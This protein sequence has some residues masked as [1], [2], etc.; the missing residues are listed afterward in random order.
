MKTRDLQKL[1]V[2]FIKKWEAKR[3]TSPS[4]NDVFIHLT[5][6]V[7]ELAAQ[8]VSERERPEKYSKEEVE[9]ALGDIIMMTFRLAD[10]HGLDME[11]VLQKIVESEL[12]LLEKD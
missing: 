9:N 12:P 10:F 8:Y 3:N 1:C 4:R 6:E 5:E 2:E 11:Q 7:G